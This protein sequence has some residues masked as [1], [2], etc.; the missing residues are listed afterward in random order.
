MKHLLTTF[1]FLGTLIS[2]GSVPPSIT[3]VSGFEL[4]RYL[5]QWYEIARLD[6]RFERGLEQVTANYSLNDDG[7]VRVENR[8]FNVD[9]SDWSTAVGKARMA[10][11]PTIGQLE[12]SF[13]GPFYGPYIIFEMDKENYQHAFV[14]SSTNA[15]W[16]LARTP[17]VSDDLKERFIRTAQ[18]A[19]Y[20]TEEL[21]MV[22][23]R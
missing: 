11:S 16:L 12:V 4:D 5:G 18:A 14:T 15:L 10:S 20:D 1:I 22:N 17:Q 23:H 8:G 2:C 13:F 3:P 6:H 9:D 19:G 21:I 7:T